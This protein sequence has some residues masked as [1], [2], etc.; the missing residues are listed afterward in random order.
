MPQVMAAQLGQT[1]YPARGPLER[2]CSGIHL[3]LLNFGQYVPNLATDVIVATDD[4]IAK[5]P[6]AVRAFLR[7]WF[8]TIDF[9]YAHK[10][11]SVEVMAEATHHS[12]A[13]ISKAYDTLIP[14]GF[15][16][17]DGR[18]D[19]KVM[20]PLPKAYVEMGFLDEPP[21]ITKL[22]TTAFLPSR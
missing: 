19:E 7:G 1:E 3:N 9:V 21:D 12:V 8:E 20:A 15:F 11:A 5:N 16:S 2:A 14:T 18:F 17:R 13:V 10:D 6:Q 22:Y 4:I